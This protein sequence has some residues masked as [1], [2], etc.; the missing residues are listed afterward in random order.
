MQHYR[1]TAARNLTDSEDAGCAPSVRIVRC[2]CAH[3]SVHAVLRPDRCV[4]R[5]TKMCCSSV[6][7]RPPWGSHCE[8]LASVFVF[9][10]TW[11][12]VWYGW[13]RQTCSRRARR[14]DL[15]SH[16]QYGS[17]STVS[18]LCG[19]GRAQRGV[20]ALHCRRL[21]QTSGWGCAS[22]MRASTT[23][24][25][26]GDDCSSCDA[27]EFGEAGWFAYIL[28]ELGGGGEECWSAHTP[29]HSDGIERTD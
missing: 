4:G 8:W 17:D 11:A 23:G 15:G 2:L 25:A 10:L 28:M 7:E 22:R 12:W 24:S 16:K 20:H 26:M 27:H 29:T 5:T 3:H 9:A 13:H 19:R 6:C 14:E 1:A 18:R 21:G